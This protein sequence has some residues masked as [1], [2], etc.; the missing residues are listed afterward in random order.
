MT[1]EELLESVR[2]LQRQQI[3]EQERDRLILALARVVPHACISDLIFYPE[4]ERSLEEIVDEALLRERLWAQGGDRGVRLWIAA[5][6][7][8]ALMDP[9]VPENHHTKFS[10]RQLLE[11]YNAR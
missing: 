10:A 9:T 7:R 4:R 3:S 11:A 8:A 6:M 5:Q 2:T 1:R